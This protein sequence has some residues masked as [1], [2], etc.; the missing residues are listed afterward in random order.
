MTSHR[1]DK[2]SFSAPYFY[3]G[4]LKKTT[5]FMQVPQD[6]TVTHLEQTTTVYV[7]KKIRR[8]ILASLYALYDCRVGLVKVKYALLN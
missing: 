8:S 7:W 6:K 3:T 2:V 1:I 5:V 4:T